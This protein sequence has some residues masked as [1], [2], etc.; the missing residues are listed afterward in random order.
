MGN[1]N[2]NIQGIGC[3]HNEKNP[4]DADLMA[5][6]FVA[7]LKR[8]GHVVEAANFTS[9]GKTDLLDIIDHAKRAA[10]CLLLFFTLAFG[11]NAAENPQA[12]RPAGPQASPPYTAGQFTVAGF[13]SYRAAEVSQL[14]GRFGYG[15]EVGY[16][17]KD[18]LS[19]NLEAITENPRHSAIDEAGL[20]FKGYLPLGKTGFASYGLLGATRTFEGE[21]FT[22][23]HKAK[24]H[25]TT[26]TTIRDGD[27]RF[28]AGA[29]VEFRASQTF[30]V[31]ADGRWTHDFNTLGHALF[32][33]GA[34]LRF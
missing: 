11:A 17:L 26:I 27:W 6:Q 32:R 2:I 30:G 22:Q 33:V 14:D 24:K 20:N 8:A 3:H 1:W 34:N 4:T 5:A 23:V 10:A 18:N 9:G 13:G 29:G 28:N 7:D 12:S 25:T 19:L 16:F 15:S 31:F 21:T